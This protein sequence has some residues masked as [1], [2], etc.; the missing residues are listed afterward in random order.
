MKEGSSVGMMLPVLAFSV[1]ISLR[2]RE[3]GPS[4]GAFSPVNSVLV[5]VM[6]KR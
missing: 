1:S 3:E 4:K 2:R 6:E 5:T